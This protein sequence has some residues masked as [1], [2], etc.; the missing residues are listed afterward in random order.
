MTRQIIRFVPVLLFAAGLT[1]CSTPQSSESEQKIAEL[2]KQLD[3]AKQE[4]AAAKSQALPAESVAG[5]PVES[6]ATAQN[7]PASEP[8]TLAS[9]G[10]SR[11]G[12]GQSD[13]VATHRPRTGA[14]GADRQERGAGFARP[15]RN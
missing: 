7:Q 4:A 13:D 3:A 8:S 6:A 10:A 5:L 11:G 14:R 1:A 12:P 15:C 9:Q 2:Q